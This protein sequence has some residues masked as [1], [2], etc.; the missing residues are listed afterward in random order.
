M[1]GKGSHCPANFLT[2]V[3]KSLFYI[4]IENKKGCSKLVIELSEVQFWSEI[5]ILVISNRTRA[6]RSFDSETTLMIPDQIP[7]HSMQLP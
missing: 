5:C 7:L 1:K 6:L 3:P 2:L 4:S